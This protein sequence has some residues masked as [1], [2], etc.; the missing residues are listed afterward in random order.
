VENI[1]MNLREVEW[2]SMDGIDVAQDRDQYKA[3]IKTVINL[4][5]P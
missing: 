3:L 4:P 5:V 2:D 1:K